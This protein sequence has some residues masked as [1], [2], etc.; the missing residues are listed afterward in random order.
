MPNKKWDIWFYAA[1]Y[2]RYRE[3]TFNSQERAARYL[4]DN[5]W[6]EYNPTVDHVIGDPPVVIIN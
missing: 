6:F 1:D 4:K 3:L 2:S 5:R